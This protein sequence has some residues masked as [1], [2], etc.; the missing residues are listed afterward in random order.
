LRKELNQQ[1]V[2]VNT[3]KSLPLGIQVPSS[4][5]TRKAGPE[6]NFSSITLNRQPTDYL[7][8]QN[9]HG[10]VQRLVLKEKQVLQLQTEIDQYK[11]QNPGDGREAVCTIS[12]NILCDTRQLYLGRTREK[13]TR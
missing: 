5:N 13:R 6:V 3:L 1:V 7:A 2:E 8:E 4:N 9:F 11:A 10:L 12:R